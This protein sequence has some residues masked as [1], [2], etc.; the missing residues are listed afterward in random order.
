M[1]G[2]GD[3]RTWSPRPFSGTA[4]GQELL[5]AEPL[6]CCHTVPSPR[7]V[8]LGARGGG[9]GTASPAAGTGQAGMGHDRLSHALLCRSVLPVPV[10]CHSMLCHSAVPC[11]AMVLCP[12]VSRALP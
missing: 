10:Q 6:C 12:V 4:R 11:H 5:L 8:S 1:A 3:T 9:H 2:L 7:L